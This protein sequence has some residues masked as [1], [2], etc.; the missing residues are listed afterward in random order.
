MRIAQ[1]IY[2]CKGAG[3]PHHVF[4]PGVRGRRRRAVSTQGRPR[5]TRPRRASAAAA[6]APRDDARRPPTRAPLPKQCDN[7]AAAEAGRRAARQ[8][9]HARRRARFPGRR[10]LPPAR[11]DSRASRRRSGASAT[12]RW[13]T[14][15]R[16][17]RLGAA[18]RC[19]ASQALYDRYLTPTERTAR[20]REPSALARVRLEFRHGPLLRPVRRA[21]GAC[22]SASSSRRGR[23]P[24]SSCRGPTRSPRSRRRS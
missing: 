2:K 3:R 19:C 7:G 4:E 17:I 12:L 15:T 10:A 14:S 20:A 6:G 18:R 16:A 8:P 22:C 9:G 5:A 24:T 23:R 1:T 21:A 13:P 11:C